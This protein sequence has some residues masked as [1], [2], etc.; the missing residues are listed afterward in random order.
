M[1]RDRL[2]FIGA[3]LVAAFIGGGVASLVF[4]DRVSA[5]ASPAVVTTG[6]INLV[7]RAGRIR[8]ILS[9]ED[10]RGLASL[11]LFDEAGERRSALTVGR[12]GSPTLQLYDRAQAA[13]LVLAVE[14]DQPALVINGEA[15]QRAVLSNLTGTPTL[16]FQDGER[17]RAE[18]GMG[19][20]GTPRFGMFGATG[21]PL[22]NL[23]VSD[24]GEPV[25]TL[26]DGTGRSRAT[27]GVVSGATVIN[28]A[29]QKSA[30]VVLGVAADGTASLSLLDAAGKVIERVPK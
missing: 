30:R 4:S 10:E 16:A 26:R 29:D 23:N 14:N 5:Q 27:M 25:V 1:T 8:G 18:V 12:D 15:G 19:R 6:Q 9:A 7:S 2:T 3:M 28:L 13:R 24:Q 11:T 22:L 21:Q 17:V 20:G